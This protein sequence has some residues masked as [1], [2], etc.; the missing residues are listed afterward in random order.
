M[1]SKK[2]ILKVIVVL[3][4]IGAIISFYLLKVKYS[5]SGFCE[6]NAKFSCNA[7]NSSSF[8]EL[9]G[10][11]VALLGAVGYLFM[12]LSAYFNLTV[13]NFKNKWLGKL[14]SFD[15]LLYFVLLAFVFTLYLFFVEFFILKTYCILCLA[16][17]VVIVLIVGSLLYIKKR[18]K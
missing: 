10:I 9:F 1:L 4:I 7:V 12:S 17:Q 14:F 16:S 5:G 8:S 13:K 6:I 3:G 18:W 15:I 11:P 2:K